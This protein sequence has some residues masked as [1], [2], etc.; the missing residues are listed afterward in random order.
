M[1]VQNIGGVITRLEEIIEQ[2]KA[3]KNRAG[4][5]AALYKRITL[6]IAEG[7][8]N[9]QFEHGSRVEKLDII[10]AQRYIDAWACYLSKS[11]SSLSWQYTFDN[12]ADKS[13]IVLQH[14][15]LGL[16]THINLDLPI[17]VAKVAPGDT[18]HDL[19][20]DFNYI[21]DVISALINDVQECLCQVWFP[22]RWLQSISNHRE[23]PVLNFSIGVARKTAWANALVLANLYGEDQQVHIRQIDEMVRQLGSRIQSPDVLS[24]FI[25]KTIRFTEFQDVSRTI[26]L[27]ETSIAD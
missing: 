26:R 14:L 27:I 1:A 24:K 6:A 21:N 25:L 23:E 2:C 15:L 17:A 22:M 13:I 12:C 4:Y 19:E 18:I 10:F 3:M 16:N 7:I 9:D 20:D 8:A 11:P 5:F